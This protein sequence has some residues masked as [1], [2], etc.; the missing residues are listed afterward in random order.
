[1]HDAGRACAVIDP[2][3]REEKYDIDYRLNCE[4]LGMFKSAVSGKVSRAGD[5]AFRKCR[6]NKQH[7]HCDVDD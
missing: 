6:H 5:E 4:N 7:T 3:R 2:V 1:M